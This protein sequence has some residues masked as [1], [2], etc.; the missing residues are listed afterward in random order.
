[1]LT[2]K[3]AR[4]FESQ[5]SLKMSMFVNSWPV[6]LVLTVPADEHWQTEENVSSSLSVAE[7]VA[8]KL[9]DNRVC[10]QSNKLTVQ[11][12]GI[13]RS[14]KKLAGITKNSDHVWFLS[15]SEYHLDDG[16]TAEWGKLLVICEYYFSLT[17]HLCLLLELY[18]RSVFFHPSILTLQLKRDAAKNVSSQRTS[19]LSRTLR[20]YST[21]R[22]FFMR[23]S[24]TIHIIN[25][26]EYPQGSWGITEGS[27]LITTY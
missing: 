4:P 18:R 16:D 5:R 10:W 13:G 25:L 1:M 24:L 2:R 17:E 20:D 26:F 6:C 19:T 15:C 14:E 22:E 23:F 21:F 11:P 8:A 7:F 3:T 9:V 27:G 12:V